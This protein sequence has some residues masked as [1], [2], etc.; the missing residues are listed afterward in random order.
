MLEEMNLEMICCVLWI[1][2]SSMVAGGK[3]SVVRSIKEKLN[4]YRFKRSMR[5]F[6]NLI[7]E[8]TLMN[9]WFVSR[10]WHGQVLQRIPLG[11]SLT[12]N[13]CP[14]MI[15]RWAVLH[16]MKRKAG[17]STIVLFT[18]CN[19][20]MSFPHAFNF[21]YSF[22]ANKKRGKYYVAAHYVLAFWSE[23]INTIMGKWISL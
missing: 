23:E 14:P 15:W 3:F 8:W 1:L 19:S 6:D 20:M 12:D 2:C 13:C 5:L 16:V 7:N 4:T 17:W 11:T 18:S 21:S 22:L 10:S 9:L